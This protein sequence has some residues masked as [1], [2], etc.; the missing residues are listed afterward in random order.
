MTTSSTITFPLHL[1][2]FWMGVFAYAYL[3]NVPWMVQALLYYKEY[4]QGD[5]ERWWALLGTK[6][7]GVMMVVLCLKLV[8]GI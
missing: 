7:L 3:G 8:V 1:L 6:A 5:N 4:Y 2:L